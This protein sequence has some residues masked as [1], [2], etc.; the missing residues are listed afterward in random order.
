[1]RLDDQNHLIVR[2]PDYAPGIEPGDRLLRVNGQDEDALLAAGVRE[3]RNA[4]EPGG[5]ATVARRCR[6]Q[7]GRHG[8]RAPYQ[9]TVAAPGGPNREVT[10]QGE[11]VTYLWQARPAPAPPPNTQTQTPSPP[12]AKP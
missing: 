8:I 5:R 11:P 12:V 7:L 6:D 2:W 3:R 10:V 4:T 1:M 9:V